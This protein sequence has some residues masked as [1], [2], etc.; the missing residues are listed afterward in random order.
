MKVILHM[1]IS[2]NG[3]IATPDNQ[4]E[5]LSHANWIEFVKAVKKSGCLIWG[6][7]TY[8]L[9][10]LWEKSY[11]EPFKNI[12]KVIISR[13]KNLKLDSGF[14]LAGSPQEALQLLK[15]KGFKKVILT[16]GATNNSAFAKLN[17]IDE[18]ILDIEGVIVGKGI[19]LFYPEG[20]ELK[21]HLKSVEKVTDN[22]IQVHYKVVK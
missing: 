5:F 22:I 2:L 4:E 9:V 18:V 8:E 19:P 12:V 16:G 13:D 6:R 15:I 3:I 17:L 20:F 21:L 7:K 14:I 1:A 11:L 10:R